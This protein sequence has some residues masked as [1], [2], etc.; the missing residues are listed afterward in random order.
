MPSHQTAFLNL[1]LG[2]SPM[3]ALPTFHRL[4]RSD[5]TPVPAYTVGLDTEAAKP[6]SVKS[7]LLDNSLSIRLPEDLART[8]LAT[9]TNFGKMAATLVARLGHLVSPIAIQH[10]ARTIRPICQLLFEV[11]KGTLAADLNGCIDA[12]M[13]RYGCTKIVPVFETSFGGGT[14][15][16]LTSLL[17][18]N[19]MPGSFRRRM[20][21]GYPDSLL[22]KPFVFGVEPFFRADA[23]RG[24]PNHESKILANAMATRI[25]LTHLLHLDAID[26]VYT[27]SKSNSG[28]V[29]L[30][31]NDEVGA[32]LGAS[33]YFFEKYL[34]SQIR[35]RTA[36]RADVNR[37]AAWYRGADVQI[38][39]T[40]ARTSARNLNDSGD[41]LSRDAQLRF[42]E[43]VMQS[44]FNG[45]HAIGTDVSH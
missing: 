11:A 39:A 9:P 34:D 24:D 1:I 43:S 20:L 10:G 33:V 2:G 41:E 31:T 36:D 4:R 37:F 14:G 3:L 18:W 6:D 45:N 22:A 7:G 32:M 15:S 35:P 40:V 21:Q 27:A 26:Y 23:N 16:A 5:S 38:T 12:I 42:R 17:A 19:F 29:S 28:G 25:E 8:L 30:S 13:R 44:T